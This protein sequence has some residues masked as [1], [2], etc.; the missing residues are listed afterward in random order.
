MKNTLFGLIVLGL[1]IGITSNATAGDKDPG[2]SPDVKP[3]PVGQEK[4]PVKSSAG[5][6]FDETATQYLKK[7]RS[8]NSEIVAAHREIYKYNNP[9][10]SNKG[11][12]L[13]EIMKN[14]ETMARDARQKEETLRDNKARAEEKITSLQKDAES[15]KVDLIKQYNGKLPKNVSDAWQTEQNYTE[16]LISKYR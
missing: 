5:S 4:T 6:A 8:I 12:N 13:G 14:Q 16:Y 9:D 3:S 1:L 10:L 11:V 2:K 7:F 15:L